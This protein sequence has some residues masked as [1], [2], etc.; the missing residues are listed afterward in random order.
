MIR[1]IITYYTLHHYRLASHLPN[2]ISLVPTY[3]SLLLGVGVWFYE[4]KWC[5]L[6]RLDPQKCPYAQF[7]LFFIFSAWCRWTQW[8]RRSCFKDSR[9]VGG[10]KCGTLINASKRATHQSRKATINSYKQEIDFYFVWATTIFWF[11]FLWE[12]A[13]PNYF[14]QSTYVCSMCL[15]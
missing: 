13:N 10:S 9:T 7:S 6:L 15:N 2:P 8:P 11:V 5:T 14:N 1:N 3:T 12:L 4:P